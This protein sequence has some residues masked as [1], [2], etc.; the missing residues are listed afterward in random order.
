MKRIYKEYQALRESVALFELNEVGV[1]KI[2]GEDHEE[3][4]NS[5]VTVDLEFMDSERTIFTL[6]LDKNANIVDVLT[7]YK[8][9]DYMLIETSPFK[10]DTVLRHIENHLEGSIQIEDISTSTAV[11]AFE[12]P[13]AWKVG[14][15]LIDIDIS[16]L[17]FQ[18]FFETKWSDKHIIF[19]RTGV[20]GEYGYKVI[21][22]NASS[23]K[24]Q[25]EDFILSLEFGDIRPLKVDMEV[26]ELAMLEVR[27]PNTKRDINGLNVFEASLE[28]MVHFDKEEFL[29]KEMLLALKKEKVSRRL[30]GFHLTS[31]HQLSTNGK[32]IVEGKLIGE[33][34]QLIRNPVTNKYTGLALL[35]DDF[36]VSGLELQLNS[37]GL[38]ENLT[39]HTISSP[40]IA[41]KSWAIKM[42]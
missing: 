40:Y 41:P 11:L 26:V 15:E 28:W 18:T 2:S 5:L 34:F 27:Q 16:S 17:P 19:A 14:Q 37:D 32:I 38:D 42:I 35:E 30:V 13:Y 12:G 29:G 8:Q 6:I 21:A 9:E 22:F 10:R 39:I 1:F 36:A 4:V 33:V 24:F 7:I 25:L 31:D 23:A 3:F 20:T